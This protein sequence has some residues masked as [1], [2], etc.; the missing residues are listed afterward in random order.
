[1]IADKPR[2]FGKENIFSGF[3][4]RLRLHSGHI[5]NIR[6]IIL[7]VCQIRHRRI[8]GQNQVFAF[9]FIFACAIL[10][11]KG[12]VVYADNFG[13]FVQQFADLGPVFLL[14]NDERFLKHRIALP[15]RF[16]N[17]LRGFSRFFASVFFPRI[18]ATRKASQRKDTGK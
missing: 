1:M 14:D 8:F 13:G 15:N 10:F 7:L 17:I 4:A 18:A 2:A 16:V 5:R 12:I 3:A 6:F 9:D 11:L